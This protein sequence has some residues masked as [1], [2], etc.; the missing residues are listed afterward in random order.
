MRNAVGFLLCKNRLNFLSANMVKFSLTAPLPKGDFVMTKEKLLQEKLREIYLLVAESLTLLDT[1]PRAPVLTLAW[2]S[3]L[4]K[5][6][7][8]A[9]IFCNYTER[10]YNRATTPLR[11]NRHFISLKRRLNKCRKNFKT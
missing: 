6:P 8:R 10:R 1:E 4:K 11:Q 2:D 3:E 5:I 9:G 7:R